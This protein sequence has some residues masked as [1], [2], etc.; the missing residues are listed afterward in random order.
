MVFGESFLN[1]MVGTV[2]GPAQAGSLCHQMLPYRGLAEESEA[3]VGE[4]RAQQPVVMYQ[5][6]VT[7]N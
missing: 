7:D 3:R 1:G 5:A 4:V 6:F 2:R